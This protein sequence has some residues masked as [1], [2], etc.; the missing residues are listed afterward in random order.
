MKIGFID[1]ASNTIDGFAIAGKECEGQ[2][3]VELVR[4]TAPD[5]LKAP[6]C[7]K[8]AFS[9]NGAD[10]AIVYFECADEDA[11]AL[12]L[13]HEKMIDVEIEHGKF[14][15]FCVILGNASE[16][17]VQERIADVVKRVLEHSRSGSTIGQALD[18]MTGAATAMSEETVSSPPASE[19]EPMSFMEDEGIHKLF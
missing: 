4:V 7:A 5:L 13:I 1:C 9:E 8:K 17:L 14:A 3:D 6:V 15:F 18:W 12:A 2:A 19:S 16:E 10:A 11:D